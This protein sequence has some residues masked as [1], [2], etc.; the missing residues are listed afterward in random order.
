MLAESL[1]INEPMSN[2]LTM[3]VPAGTINPITGH[4]DADDAALFRAIGPDQPDPPSVSGTERTTHIPFGWI[5]P[6][7]GGM[8]EPR[9]YI[10]GGGG[11]PGGGPPGGGPPRGG[12]LLRLVGRSVR[13][14]RGGVILKSTTNKG[15]LL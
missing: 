13:R 7:G 6:Q 1:N 12:P 3:E 11:P 5:R 8:P 2:T 9:R 14:A 10:Y 15:G 4:I